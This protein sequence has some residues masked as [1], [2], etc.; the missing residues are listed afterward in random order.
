[1]GY[2]HVRRMGVEYED[3]R[4]ALRKSIMTE[5]HS[6]RVGIPGSFL[7]VRI[8]EECIAKLFGT[9]RWNVT[10]RVGHGAMGSGVIRMLLTSLARAREFAPSVH[11]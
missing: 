3:M 5:R 9:G 1:M 11:I 10:K 2:R 4:S 7:C 8:A 6:F